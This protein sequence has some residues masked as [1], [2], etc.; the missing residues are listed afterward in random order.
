M[1]ALNV[2]NV[3]INYPTNNVFILEDYILPP[4]VHDHPMLCEIFHF[5]VLERNVRNILNFKFQPT[6]FLV[7]LVTDDDELSRASREH[8]HHH[9]IATGR[10]LL[11]VVFTVVK[12]YLSMYL[13][14]CRLDY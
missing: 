13:Q 2:L 3:L 14:Y 1:T 5:G 9:F 11:L 4:N 7:L 8:L 12:H 10:V 6:A